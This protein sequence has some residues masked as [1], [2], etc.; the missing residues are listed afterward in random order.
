MVVDCFTF[1][2][3]L[4]LLEI[5][6]NELNP[7]VDKFVL[8]EAT[9]TH[10]FKPKPLYY[11]ENKERFSN[12]HN[13]IVHVVVDKYPPNPEN[14][15]WIYE[16]HQRNMIAE[17]LKGFSDDDFIL[18]SD[19]DEIPRP[20][21]IQQALKND[22]MSIF[23]QDCYYYFIN[24][25]NSSPQ[26]NDEPYKWTG[27]VMAR[28]KLIDNKFSPQFLRDV[29]IHALSANHPRFI[30]RMVWKWWKFKKLTLKGVPVHFMQ[31]AGWHFSYLG[32]V[33]RIIAKIESFAHNEFNKPEF[34]NPERIGE[35]IRNGEDIFGRGYTYSFVKVDDTYPTYILNNLKKFSSL[36]MH[37]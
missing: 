32:G 3:E 26:G 12:F 29:S 4:D 37:T 15:P 21:S 25:I 20:S 6:L 34:K 17:G 36:I 8:V 1:F 19:L 16:R 23:I 7:V 11:A 14:T 28:K 31:N 9:H 13:K 27:T 5:R 22:G 24:C 10:Q 30:S 33:D 18:V 35:A 2:N